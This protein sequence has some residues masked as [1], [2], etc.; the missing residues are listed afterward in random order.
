M[1]INALLLFGVSLAWAS[2]Y[3][4]IG[5]AA[6]DAPP[7]TATAVMTW[8]A[9]VLMVPGVHFGLRRDLLQPL[10]RRAWVPAVMG[11]TAL[12]LPNLATVVGERTIHPDLAS[13][14]GTTVPIATLL[15]TTFVLR[16]QRFSWVRLAGAGLGVAGLVLFV[17]AE[18]LLANPSALHGILIQMTGGLVFAL[19]GLFVA[20]QT[21]DLDAPS[22]A[23]WT[24]VAGAVA[25][26]AAAFLFEDPL[27]VDL[28]PRFVA[29]LLG[30]GVLGMALA[31]LGYY[32]L[33]ARAGASFASYYA[34]LVPPLG[35]VAA[36]VALGEGVTPRHAAGVAV[37]LVGLALLTR[38]D[39]GPR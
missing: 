2:G 18:D 26:T 3:L 30:E 9:A 4:F 6:H 27:A 7:I 36:A 38:R 10:R 33:V 17:G 35:V 5:E 16:Q 12:A 21:A 20:R 1:L 34:F 23:A 22:L 24:M 19:N 29:A 13:V 28:G 11:L 25:L 8:I 37:V 15:L 39:P 14:L 32:A 31:Y